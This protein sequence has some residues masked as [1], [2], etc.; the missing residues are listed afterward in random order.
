MAIF[1]APVSHTNDALSSVLAGLEMM[2]RLRDFNESQ[3]GYGAPEFHIGVGINYGIVT[4]GNIGC[5]K[6]M[7]YTVIGDSVNLA[8][9]L[10][11]LTKKYQESVLFSEGV[12][13]KITQDLP[14]RVID[15]VAVKGKTQGV[16]IFTSRL[17]LSDEE[18]VAW[19]Y[20]EEAAFWYYQRD[21]EKALTGFQRVLTLLSQDPAALRFQERCYRYIAAPPPED[22]DGVEVMTEK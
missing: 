7:N 8:S 12:Y 5:D 9:R 15:R 20:H 4:V 10:E 21:F 1:G 14:C 3:K 13:T 17:R 2:E 11:G 22:W 18:K 16:P 19:K 6:K